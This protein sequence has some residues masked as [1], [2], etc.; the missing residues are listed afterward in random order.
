MLALSVSV[1]S[2][3][4]LVSCAPGTRFEISCSKKGE[5]VDPTGTVSLCSYCWVWRQLPN[6]YRPRYINELIC[7]TSD[8]SCLSGERL[9]SEFEN[10]NAQNNNLQVMLN[11]Q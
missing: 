2:M 11:V 3:N 4:N 8:D 9:P 5:S 10:N 1:S 7:S 6:N